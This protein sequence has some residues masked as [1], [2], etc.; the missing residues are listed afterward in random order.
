L[1]CIYS[2]L[3]GLGH[4]NTE[5]LVRVDRGRHVSVVVTELVKSNDSI[6]F[7]GV[8]KAHE[9]HIDVLRILV[10]LNT[11]DIVNLSDVVKLH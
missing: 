11:A 9:L 7:L 2:K 3:P 8:P 10:S 6:S 5:V 1:R 4:H